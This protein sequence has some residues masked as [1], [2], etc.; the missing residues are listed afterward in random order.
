[1]QMVQSQRQLGQIELDVFFG[2]HDLKFIFH[3]N[4]KRYNELFFN[5]IKQKEREQRVGSVN[6]RI[7]Q[8]L[9]GST[10]NV[11]SD[12]EKR[13]PQNRNKM[14]TFHPAAAAS[15]CFYIRSPFTEL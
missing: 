8:I 4:Y 15:E 6:K 12:D 11:K 10:P 1:M 2:E 14:Q 13:K 5:R 9:V 7:P 3:H